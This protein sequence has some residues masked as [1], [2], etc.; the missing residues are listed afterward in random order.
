MDEALLYGP[1]CRVRSEDKNVMSVDVPTLTYTG[2]TADDAAHDYPIPS[3]NFYTGELDTAMTELTTC[4]PDLL[5]LA[6]GKP[7]TCWQMK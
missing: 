6:R 2:A 4:L 7:A 1:E 3:S 5:E